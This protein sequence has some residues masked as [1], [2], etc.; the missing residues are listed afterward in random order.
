VTP[1][2]GRF[3]IDNERVGSSS[4]APVENPATLEPLGEVCLASS[5]DCARAVEAAR[6][7]FPLW[8][9][10][11]VEGRKKIFLR[12][13]AILVRRAR[14]IARLI[15][16]EKGTP[17]VESQAVEVFSIME[18]LDHYGH[19]Q[20]RSRAPRK[21]SAHVPFFAHKRNRYLFEALGPSL[22]ISPWNFP[23]MLPF[24]DVISD[25]TVGNTVVL[26]PSTSTPFCG[27]AIG[28]IMTEA[29]LPAGVLNVVPCRVPQA[30]EMI[31]NPAVQSISFTGSVGVGKRIME[32]ASRNLTNVVLELGG[33]DPTIVL[34]DAD[35]ELAARGTVWAAFMNA[36]QSC[37]SVE[38]VYVAEPVAE[39]FIRRVAEITPSLRIGNPL[40]P[41]V[42]IGP[43]ENASQLRL[44]EEH[45]RDAAEKGAETLCGG[46]RVESLAGYFFPPTV[47]VK[48]DHSM[49]VMTEET[50]G[51]VLP[52]MTFRDEE[53]AVALA[54]DS[55]YGL[56]AS[57]WTR[58]RKA[59]ARL[60][61]RL[62]A[63][64]VTINDH[65]MTFNEP[66]A[67]WGG[68]KQTGMGRTH[69]PYG[70]LEIS[71]IKFVSADFSGKR[72]RMWW[73]PY[74]ASKQRLL[75]KAM[76]LMHHPRIGQRIKALLAMV[77]DLKSVS[78]TMPL[79][80][81]LKITSRLFHK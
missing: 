80:S 31:L 68:I 17:L 11:T 67:I 42:D 75:E 4:T 34:A 48:V 22:V 20:K 19:N 74:P 24:L 56:T 64:G 50:F 25:L 40:D 9:E 60:A 55:R 47:L 70:L 27:L 14:E 36:G 1:L 29:G 2:D 10:V 71:N 46:R 28:D 69:G 37:A 23:F 78:A 8:R 81:L 12:A 18:A 3:L 54:N 6:R 59:A 49:K 63:G 57:V 15:S 7:A 32:L 38:R 77:P 5:E 58:D 73:F 62:E 76:I 26:R 66:K 41:D 16:L 72:D 51:P 45:V 61:G 21:V 44:V 43:M 33:K 65:M 13:R 35:I 52:V 30:E 39:R 79:R 53:E